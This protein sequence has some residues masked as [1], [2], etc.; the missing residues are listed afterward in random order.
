VLGREWSGDGSILLTLKETTAAIFT[1][2]ADFDPQGYAE[3]TALPSPWD[4]APPTITSIAARPSV[5]SDGS[6]ISD[7]LVTWTALTAAAER[8]GRVE[9]QWLVP[10]FEIQ[11]VSVAGD[12]TQAVLPGVPEGAVIIVGR[13]WSRL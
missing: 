10:G 13:A 8:S 3:N 12:M 5:L 11:T 4:I 2:D 6:L 9:V 1:M 7:V